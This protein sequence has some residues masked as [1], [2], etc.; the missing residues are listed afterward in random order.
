MYKI[1][2][3]SLEES[4]DDSDIIADAVFSADEPDFVRSE[5]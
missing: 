2:V 1:V 3:T 4:T 5:R